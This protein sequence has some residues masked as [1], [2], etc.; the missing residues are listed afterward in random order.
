MDA[1]DFVTVGMFG[2][3][4]D[5]H[6]GRALLLS[7]GLEAM[8]AADDAGGYQPQ[9]GLSNGVRLMVRAPYVALAMSILDPPESHAAGSAPVWV[10]SVAVLL[11]GL[12]L[13]LIGLPLIL[14]VLRALA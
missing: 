3:R 13:G 11:S 8:V 9:L 5:A 14:P 10:T 1:S 2:S 6:V 7:E 4:A 12:L